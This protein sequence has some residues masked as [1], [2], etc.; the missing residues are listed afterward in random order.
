MFYS[1]LKI[2]IKIKYFVEIVYWSGLNGTRI[3]PIRK[4]KKYICEIHT[5]LLAETQDIYCY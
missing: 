2:K 5:I 1:I 3:F 4:K